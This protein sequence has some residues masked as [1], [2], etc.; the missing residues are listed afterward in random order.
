MKMKKTTL[1]TQKGLIEVELNIEKNKISYLKIT[2]DFFIY[3]EEA[4]EI[5]EK[6]LLNF[7]I[8]EEQ[9]KNKV[10]EIYDQQQ[11]STPGITID[12]WVTVILKA[13]NL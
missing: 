11:I 6:E 7:E 3:P 12:D 2:G 5:F 1:R 9:L 8:D 10:R 4:L 13:V